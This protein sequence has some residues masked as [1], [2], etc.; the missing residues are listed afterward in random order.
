MSVNAKIGGKR[1]LQRSISADLDRDRPCQFCVTW[2]DHGDLC[3]GGEL[4]GVRFHI[5][6]SLDLGKMVKV[7]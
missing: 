1:A 3:L 2:T 5:D 7:A 6:A 4:I